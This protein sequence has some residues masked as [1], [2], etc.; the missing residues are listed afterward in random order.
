[1]VKGAWIVN[2]RGTGNVTFNENEGNKL[3]WSTDGS[4]KVVYG[5]ELTEPIYLGHTDSRLLAHNSN[6]ELMLIPQ[7]LDEWN[8][9]TDKEQNIANGAYILILCRVEAVHPGAQHPE[10]EIM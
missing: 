3:S 4:T 1:M 10:A 2:A 7:E 8:L 5:Y 9:E 6:S